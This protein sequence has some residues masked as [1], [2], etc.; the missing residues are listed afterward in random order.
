[1]Q[2]SSVEMRG[3]AAPKLAIN[4]LSCCWVIL[5]RLNLGMR[6]TSPSDMAVRQGRARIYNKAI[7]AAG[8]E[9]VSAS[10]PR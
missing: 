3:R 8:A 4:A 7:S 1:M 5:Q 2:R 6:F 9:M 10:F